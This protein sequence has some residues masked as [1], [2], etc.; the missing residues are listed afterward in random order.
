MTRTQVGRKAKKNGQY[1]ENFLDKVFNTCSQLGYCNIEKTPEP[2][3]FIKPYSTN[4]FVGCYI[5]SAQPD[6]KGTLKGGRS[7]VLEAKSV[8]TGKISL[9]ALTENEMAELVKHKELGACTGV[10]V[11]DSAEGNIY[12]LPI[13]MFERMQDLFNRKHIKLKEVEKF[14]IN[15]KLVNKNLSDLFSFITTRTFE[16]CQKLIEL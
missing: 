7:I 13:V 14:C 10:I 9:S 5:K 3:R 2:F 4:L 15:T 1:F 16:D 11:Y 6:Y 12:L 8:S